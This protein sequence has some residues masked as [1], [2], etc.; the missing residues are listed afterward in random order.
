MAKDGRQILARTRLLNVIRRHGISV[1]R[2]LEQK[3]SDAGPGHQRIDP[4]VLTTVRQQLVDEGVL[5]TRTTP[6]VNNT[7]WFSLTG[8][9]TAFVQERYDAQLPVH[10]AIREHG[11]TNRLGQC[12]EIAVYRTLLEQDQLT[13]F[14][15][16]KDLDDHDD[17]TLYSKEEPPQ[18]V[19]GKHLARQQRLDFLVL[20]STAELGGIEV[21]NIREWLY[22]GREEIRELLIKAMALDCVPILIARRI[23][24]TT[25]KV[26]KPCG[27]IL[28]QTYNQRWAEADQE[29]AEKARDKHLLGYHDIRVGNMPDERLLKFI[30]TNLPKVMPHARK[31]F[32]QHK[33]LIG[34]F[35]QNEMEY[36]EF[37]A[38]VRRRNKGTNEDN[39]WESNEM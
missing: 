39:D 38:R 10:Q 28:H 24:F 3:I 15:R 23:H 26:L 25:F 7:P 14:G 22:P 11:V 19:S 18:S 30:G 12:L 31:R 35:V 34:K 21:K 6:G 33:D 37:A 20:S 13:H 17:S 2:T 5:L 32:E 4:H 8:A 29:L 16:F 27:V 36:K 9:D 1:A